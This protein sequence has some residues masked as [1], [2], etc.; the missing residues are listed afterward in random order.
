[1]FLPN[2]LTSPEYSYTRINK[3]EKHAK[4]IQSAPQVVETF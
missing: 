2:K 3:F 1:M 4:W